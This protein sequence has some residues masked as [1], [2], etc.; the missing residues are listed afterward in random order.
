MRQRWEYQIVEWGRGDGFQGTQGARG[1]EMALNQ[2]GSEGWE[3]VSVGWSWG[4]PP[5]VVILK[6]PEHSR[7][8]TGG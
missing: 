8:P 1:L 5:T 6:R 3:V 2:R 4:D 7:A